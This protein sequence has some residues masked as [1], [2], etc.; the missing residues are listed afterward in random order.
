MAQLESTDKKK[1]DTDRLTYM[2]KRETDVGVSLGTNQWTLSLRL[3][4][5]HKPNF[6]WIF[7]LSF[8]YVC[9]CVCFL[10]PLFLV[11]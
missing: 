2:V 4:S 6:Y 1:K 3:G 9:V 8:F 10:L 11:H 7:F 5:G